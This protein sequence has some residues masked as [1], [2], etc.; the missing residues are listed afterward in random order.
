MAHSNNVDVQNIRACFS[1]CGE[2]RYLLTIPYNSEEQRTEVFSVILKNPSSA[3]ENF[4]DTSVNRVENYIY[5]NF[6]RCRELH[7]LNLFAYRA[8]DLSDLRIRID[9]EGFSNAV[10]SA[11]DR[12]LKNSFRDST[13]I[14]VAWGGP[15]EITK[16]R[17]DNRIGEVH[18]LL[19][20]YRNRLWQVKSPGRSLGCYPKH[21][22]VWGYGYKY[23][24]YQID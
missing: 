10:G 9:E 22:Q 21:A 16:S 4:A 6:R 2:Y 19:L 18:Q 20:P 14:I 1:Q 7:I 23:N 5:R 17:Y 13:R 8:T 12:F 24:R 15:G 3:D 11:N